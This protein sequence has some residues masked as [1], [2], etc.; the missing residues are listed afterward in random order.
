[1][2]QRAHW[3]SVLLIVLLACVIGL[4]TLAYASPPDPTWI[5]G[6]YDAGD[7]DDVVWMLVELCISDRA[8]AFDTADVLRACGPGTNAIS[9]D[10]SSFIDLAALP[11]PPPLR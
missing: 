9:K 10:L 4:S 3:D 8:P 6:I 2:H 1:M 7:F 5:V 11:R